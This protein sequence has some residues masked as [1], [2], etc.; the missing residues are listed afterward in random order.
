[1]NK[2]ILVQ[3]LPKTLLVF[4]AAASFWWGCEPAGKQ[5]GWND[6]TQI[7]NASRGDSAMQAAQ[8]QARATVGAFITLLRP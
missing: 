7:Y 5:P 8:Q 6:D 1:M 4:G 3:P 2:S